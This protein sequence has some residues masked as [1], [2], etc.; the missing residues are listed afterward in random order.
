MKIL[1]IAS[2]GMLLPFATAGLA[3]DLK[4]LDTKLG[5][6]E[7]TIDTAGMPSM[8][9]T[10]IPKETLEKMPAAQRAQLE[11]MMKNQA[12]GSGKQ[13]A[14]TK[15]CMTKESQNR[16]YGMPES[17]GVNCKR[18]IVSSTSSRTELHVVCTSA[19]GATKSESDVLMERI[20]S[21]HVRGSV[22]SKTSVRDSPITIKIAINSKWLTSDC[23]DVKPQ[24]AK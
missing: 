17:K 3:D 11:A 10:Q 2:A 12:G 15:S 22:T 14:T 18:Q 6:W 5:L 8:A 21:E 4:P 13:T 9:M 1:L 7:T 24:P 16:G 23:G 20:D 19:T